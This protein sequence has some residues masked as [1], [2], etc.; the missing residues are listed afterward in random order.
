MSETNESNQAKE[1]KTAPKSSKAKKTTKS[2]RTNKWLSIFSTLLVVVAIIVVIALVVNQA[3]I[4]SEQHIS[5]STPETVI[6]WVECDAT[7]PTGGFF[8]TP[9]TA[10]DNDHDLKIIYHGDNAERISYEYESGYPSYVD[11][12]EAEAKLHADF[13][14]FTGNLAESFNPSFARDGDELKIKL[15]SDFSELSRDTAE[16]FFISN[17]E[18]DSMQD[19]NVK[20]LVEIYQSKGFHCEYGSDD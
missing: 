4:G 7:N 5:R 9:D 15:I 18:F 14:E 16:L 1:A 10:L 11:A 20:K 2:N 13:N 3:M 12:T 19:Y 17:E 6:S 8:T